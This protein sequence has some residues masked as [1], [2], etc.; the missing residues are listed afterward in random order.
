MTK[1]IEKEGVYEINIQDLEEEVKLFEEYL[2]SLDY[3]IKKEG[4]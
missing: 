2:A 1:I 4:I 3:A